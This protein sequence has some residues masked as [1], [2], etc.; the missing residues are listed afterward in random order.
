MSLIPESAR[1]MDSLLKSLKNEGDFD[2]ET[3]KG[4]LEE[5]S[6]QVGVDEET[7]GRMVN[8]YQ[9]KAMAVSLLKFVF[10]DI[11]D[12]NR[13]VEFF[14]QKPD[15]KLLIEL[16]DEHEQKGKTEGVGSET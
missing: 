2:I 13:A 6:M 9:P 11:R 16:L 3:E 15:T 1:A 14:G 8:N 12:Y 7:A 5:K 10:K 4:L